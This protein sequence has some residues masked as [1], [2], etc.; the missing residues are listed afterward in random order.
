MDPALW[1]KATALLDQ[2]MAHK[3][4]ED[5]AFADYQVEP[6]TARWER[7]VELR[8]VTDASLTKAMDAH[9]EITRG[10]GEA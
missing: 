7:F 3:Q 8:S 5:Q 10:I 4:A 1:N 9:A 6:T 2:A